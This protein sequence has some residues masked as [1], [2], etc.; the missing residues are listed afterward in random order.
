MIKA[1]LKSIREFLQGPK[2]GATH[3]P[4][5]FRQGL[6][7]IGNI[8][9]AFPESI[10]PVEEVGLFGNALPQEVYKARHEKEPNIEQNLEMHM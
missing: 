4:A 5:A 6:K 2:I 3:A 10:K 8:L 1:L 9:P 7:E